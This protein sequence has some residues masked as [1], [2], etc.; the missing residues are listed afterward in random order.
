[1]LQNIKFKNLEIKIEKSDATV[2]YT[3]TGGVD[4]NFKQQE[5]LR[6]AAKDIIFD[7]GEIN[8]FNSCGIRE[9]VH[10][11]KDMN[12][13]GR[14]T[15]INCSITMIDQI[16]LVPDTLGEAAISSFAAPYYC[17]EHGELICKIN[18]LQNLKQLKDKISPQLNCPTCN[19]PLEFDALEESY[20]LFAEDING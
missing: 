6:I 18:V 1:M 5:I 4:E 8:N 17:A 2:T 13:L 3:F 10:F 19:K 11:M 15:F 12:P 7:L 9:W 16:N 14:I 20:F